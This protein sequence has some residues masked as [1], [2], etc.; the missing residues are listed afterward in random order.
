[1]D[2]LEKVREKF[3]DIIS[4]DMMEDSGNEELDDSNK[5]ATDSRINNKIME[6]KHAHISHPK[7]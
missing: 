3:P 6:K 4:P 7:I 1:M 2:T 5:N